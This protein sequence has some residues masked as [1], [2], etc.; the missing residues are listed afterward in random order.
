ML[1]VQTG[2]VHNQPDDLEVE[3]ALYFTDDQLI[4]QRSGEPNSE[5]LQHPDAEEFT[6]KP[7]EGHKSTIALL[8]MEDHWWTT[9]PDLPGQV[10]EGMNKNAPGLFPVCYGLVRGAFGF[11]NPKILEAYQKGNDKRIASLD[12]RYGRGLCGELYNVRW[13]PHYFTDLER[14]EWMG[15]FWRHVCDETHRICSNLH[16]CPSFATIMLQSPNNTADHRA[17]HL[18]HGEYWDQLITVL[19]EKVE[20]RKIDGVVVW[21]SGWVYLYTDHKDSPGLFDSLNLERDG[22]GARF[23]DVQVQLEAL[24]KALGMGPTSSPSYWRMGWTEELDIRFKQLTTLD[25]TNVPERGEVIK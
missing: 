1:I 11:D 19:R 6:K 9:N 21:G 12:E 17:G 13:N 8:N 18:L 16:R 10:I 23:G 7:D 2:E 14:V 24:Q 3:Q 25:K 20:E 15:N 22:W 4:D 5:Y